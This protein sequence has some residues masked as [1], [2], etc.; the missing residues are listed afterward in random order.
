MKKIVH[1]LET[2][3]DPED[4]FLL[5]KYNYHPIKDK[6][7]NI[8]LR[9][10]VRKNNKCETEFLHKDIINPPKGMQVDHI[11]GDTLDNRKCNLRPCTRLQ[12]QYNRSLYKNNKSGYKGVSFI[13]R[14]KK[15]QATLKINGEV[16][17]LGLYSDPKKA[18]IAYD[19]AAIKYYGEFSRTN[20]PKENYN[21]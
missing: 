2:Q 15:Y 7:N 4:V 9:R 20:F 12:N 16:K 13:R 8:Y 3:I 19:L 14:Q 1:G 17:Y 11:N 10:S 21:R 18:A 5:K 6:G